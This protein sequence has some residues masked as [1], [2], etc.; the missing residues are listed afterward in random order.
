MGG[1][2]LKV[3]KEKG[4]T[5]KIKLIEINK[6]LEINKQQMKKELF[7]APMDIEEG[8]GEC[9]GWMDGQLRENGLYVENDYLHYDPTKFSNIDFLTRLVDEGY[10]GILQNSN[11]WEFMELSGDDDVDYNGSYID[12]VIESIQWLL[13]N[14]KIKEQ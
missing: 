2:V 11:I 5:M 4:T 1:T 12:G 7:F 10:E 13:K 9:S 8:L 3:N 6:L 14:N